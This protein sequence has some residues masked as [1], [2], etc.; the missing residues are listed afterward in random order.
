M[1]DSHR[2]R[3]CCPRHGLTIAL[4][5]QTCKRRLG[6]LIAVSDFLGPRSQLLQFNIQA[7][8]FLINVNRCAVGHLNG[9]WRWAVRHGPP[10]VWPKGARSEPSSRPDAH[11]P[12]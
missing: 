12:Y 9:I 5:D 10:S 7:P 4:L 1:R 8:N 2:V 6:L 3:D 11:S